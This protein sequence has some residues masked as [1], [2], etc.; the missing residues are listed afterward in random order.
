MQKPMGKIDMRPQYTENDSEET[1]DMDEVIEETPPDVMD[2]EV[3]ESSDEGEVKED[4]DDT[5]V[6]EEEKPDDEEKPVVAKQKKEETDVSP[7]IQA[8]KDEEKRIRDQ[9]SELR[10]ERREVRREKIEEPIVVDK[11]DLSDVADADVVLIE[12]VLKAKGYIRKDEISVAT[13]KEKV[14][15]F[16]DAWL[17]KHPEYLPENDTDDMNWN[18]L[19]QTVGEY[20]KLPANPKD[21]TKILDAA[22]SMVRPESTKKLPVK[23]LA[24][25][26][27]AKEK[28][29]IASKGSGGSGAKAGTRSMSDR[30]KNANTLRDRYEGFTDE[31]IDEFLR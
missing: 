9:I 10:K 22:H 1:I 15:S 26:E 11:S 12:K 21:I 2:E 24:A 20:F 7:S 28:V 30:A 27:A 31:E 6:V 5:S 16:K 18:K 4:Q 8:L 14:E 19:N 29:T 3:K 23:S 25:T 17:E 13:H